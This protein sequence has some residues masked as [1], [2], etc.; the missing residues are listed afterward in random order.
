VHGNHLVKRSAEG[1]PPL[2]RA[3]TAPGDQCRVNIIDLLLREAGW[4]LDKA[5]DREYPVA[6]LPSTKSGPG[7]V[8]ESHNAQL[9][10]QRAL[11]D[12]ERTR[13]ERAEAQLETE[14]AE[15]RQLTTHITGNG[16]EPPAPA[17]TGA[18]SK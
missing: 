17:R 12:A 2:V 13:A 16:H 5:E 18:R 10:A 4:L 3:A 11:T 14:C 6:G 15:R 7:K 1:P 9:E 8:R